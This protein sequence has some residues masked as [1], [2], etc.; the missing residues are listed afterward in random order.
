MSTDGDFLI[1]EGNK[2]SRRGF[3]FKTFAMSAIV[4][5]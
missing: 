1:F 5:S 3:L 2:Y 4:S